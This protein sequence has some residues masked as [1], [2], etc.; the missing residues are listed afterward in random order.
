M[1]HKAELWL[2]HISCVSWKEPTPAG[3]SIGRLLAQ[4]SEAGWA[5]E[6]PGTRLMDQ[7]P[8]NEWCISQ[9]K[10]WDFAQVIPYRCKCKHA[11]ARIVYI[12]E[13]FT[14][15][16]STAA[17]PHLRFTFVAVKDVLLVREFS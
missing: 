16:W 17:M 7:S 3:Y 15:K 12:N 4:G 10:T 5:W 13:L 1:N 6:H 11:G 8:K 2:F 14:H 9:V